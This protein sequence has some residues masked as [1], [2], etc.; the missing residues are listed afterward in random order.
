M[1]WGYEIQ[2]SRS[3]IRVYECS[4]V[5]KYQA[6]WQ[7]RGKQRARNHGGYGR[8]AQCKPP[9]E[10]RSSGGRRISDRKQGQAHGG[11][12]T[13]L[14]LEMTRREF[15]LIGEQGGQE[16]KYQLGRLGQSRNGRRLGTTGPAVR[17]W[18]CC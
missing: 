1:N 15:I 12:E 2:A 9:S 16:S 6:V 10:G 11:A 3:E 13:M 8:K 18:E 7:Q 5:S 14:P 4:C 17:S